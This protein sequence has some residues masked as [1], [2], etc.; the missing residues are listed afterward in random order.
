MWW[1]RLRKQPRCCMPIPL[2]GRERQ[3]DRQGERQTETDRQTGRGRGRGREWH[4]P[5]EQQVN[6][7]HTP[8]SR[9]LMRLVGVLHSTQIHRRG[10][11][12][13]KNCPADEP[14]QP[15]RPE[16]VSY[17]HG[18]LVTEG[19]EHLLLRPGNHGLA[20][21]LKPPMHPDLQSAA[22][23]PTVRTGG[24]TQRRDWAPGGS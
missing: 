13:G 1:S 9:A 12:D 7:Q 10:H 19:L 20:E 17:L 11:A 14:K 16:G 2:A 21:D 8:E 5:H 24:P 18:N 22:V 3:T 4:A 6:R 15:A 23:N